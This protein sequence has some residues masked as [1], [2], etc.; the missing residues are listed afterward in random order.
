MPLFCIGISYK[1]AAVSIR[2]KFA[3]SNKTII[4]Q[5]ATLKEIVDQGDFVILSS[6][7]RV[8]YYIHSSASLTTIFKRLVKFWQEQDIWKPSD[9]ELFYQ[10][11]SEEVPQHL[12]SVLSGIDS[13]VLGETEIVKQVKDAYHFC[14]EQKFT[15]KELNQLFQKS[16]S[17]GKKIRTQTQIQTGQVSVGSVAVDLAAKIFGQLSEQK[18]M[19]VGAGENS[20]VTAQ[21]LMSRGANSVIVSNRSYDKA[22][23]LAEH[24]GGSAIRF[25]D[26]EATLAEV[27][28][29][30]S[31]TGSP[32][33]VVEPEHIEKVRKQRKYKELCIIDLAIPR[34]VNPAVTDFPEVYLY[35]MDTLSDLADKGKEHR[36]QQV[37]KA[38]AI[39]EQAFETQIPPAERETPNSDTDSIAA[40][41]FST[42]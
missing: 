17:V 34:D 20:R 40:N 14:L 29:I 15:G 11:Q 22:V 28:I 6:C 3:I 27:D 31:S 23:E 13:M 42:L 5:Q 9:Q 10:Y 18:T 39:I 37:T 35:D 1:Q 16:F 41:N 33:F 7:N 38:Q 21:S 4:E 24:L 32:Y 2:E 12:C 26:W 19:I 36:Q 25:D 8:E 30:I